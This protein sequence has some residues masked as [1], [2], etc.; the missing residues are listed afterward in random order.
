MYETNI[1]RSFISKSDCWQACPRPG[2]G[3]SVHCLLREG[4]VDVD[5]TCACEH[6]FC[7]HCR[8]EEHQ[9]LPCAMVSAWQ[10]VIE[11]ECTHVWKV[12]VGRWV[13]GGV[14]MVA[15]GLWLAGVVFGVRREEYS[16]E[17]WC[18]GGSEL[19]WCT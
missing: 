13:L 3:F 9:P 5:V 11:G 12:V 18:C 7:W 14:R 19:Y 15:G 17:M 2:C 4:E 8:R 16:V 10:M 6:R 1:V